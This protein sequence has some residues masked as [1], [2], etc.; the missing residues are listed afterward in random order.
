M[1]ETENGGI[2]LEQ[3]KEMISEFSAVNLDEVAPEVLKVTFREFVPGAD[4]SGYTIKVVT[5]EIHTWVPMFLFNRMLA[6]QKRMQKLRRQLAARDQ[7]EEQSEPETGPLDLLQEEEQPFNFSALT[8]EF[9]REIMNNCEPS[10]VWQA[11]E[12]LAVWKL[13]PGEEQMSLKRLVLGL[14]FEQIAGLFSRFFGAMLRQ[15][16][17]RA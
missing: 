9:F 4:G 3:A 10:V 2:T 12:V 17:I 16:Q 11:K 5:K 8:D 6:N 15:R 1:P 7:S 14:S 13:T